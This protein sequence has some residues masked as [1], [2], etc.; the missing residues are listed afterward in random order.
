MRR[1]KFPT[2]GPAWYS[3]C[4]EHA[5]TALDRSEPLKMGAEV[6]ASD[7]AAGELTRVIVNPI[8]EAVTHLVVS[9]QHHSGPGRL[10]PLDLVDAVDP[11]RIRLRCSLAEFAALDVAEDIQ[12]LPGTTDARGY[13]GNAM[14]WPLF[15]IEAPTATTHHGGAMYN[16]RVPLGEVEVRRGDQVHA[17]DGWIGAVEGL[18]IDRDDHHVTH[19]LLQEGHL[20]GRKRVAIPIGAA[21]RVDNE[22]RVALSKQEVEN[23]P[24]VHLASGASG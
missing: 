6:F 3:L 11:I 13:G 16:D 23:L 17:T 20:W 14:N 9:P 22:V 19:V 18:V 8:A 24:P 5:M 7:G 21:S 4:H 10:V 2:R 12:F 1:R 15:G